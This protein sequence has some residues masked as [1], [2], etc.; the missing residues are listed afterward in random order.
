MSYHFLKVCAATPKIKLGDCKYNTEQIIACMKQSELEGASLTLFPELCITGYTCGDLFFQSTLLTQTQQSIRLLLQESTKHEQLFVIGA[1]IAYEDHLYNTAIVICKGEILGIVPKTYLP[2][3]NEYYEKRWFHSANDRI[4]T[5]ISY[6]DHTV[7][8]SPYLLFQAE[9]IPY[10]TVGIEVCEDLWAVISPSLYHTLAG[11]TVILNPSASNE[12]VGKDSY[13]K[14]LIAQQS[15]RTM[16]SYIYTSSGIGESTTD[17]VFGGH[18]LIYENGHQIAESEL[19]KRDNDLLYG[20]IDLERVFVERMKQNNFKEADK[21]KALNYQTLKFNIK[22]KCFKWDRA[23]DPRPFVPSDENLRKERCKH[24]FNIQ[25]HALAR[26]MEHIQCQKLVLGISGGLDSTLALLVCIKATQILGFSPSHILG[27]TMPG[28]GTS[29]RTYHNAITLMQL[30]GIS[31]KE[32]SIVE[33]VKAHLKD[34]EHDINLHDITYENAQARERTQILMDLSNQFNGIV[35]GTGDL[36]E[37]ALG[38]ATYNGDHMSMYAVNASI[39]KTLVRYL[40]E[41]AAYYESEQSAQAI[42][43]DILDTPVS[44]ELLPLDS[45]GIIAQKTEDIVGPYELHDFYLYYMLRFGFSP[46]KIYF[47]AQKAFQDI[48]DAKTIL[49]WLEIFYKRFFT[50]QFKRSCLPDG[51]K[52]GSICLSPRGDWRMPSDAHNRI[53]LDEIEH[54][55]RN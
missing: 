51:P 1:P 18:K 41:Y 21:I 12:I 43:L 36:S 40:V 28:F 48:Y 50:Q 37:L 5:S 25:A 44:P 29:D 19:F 26:R 22:P 55:K 16:S 13:R 49:K 32:I 52:V 53:W 3:Y 31:V 2:N 4:H 17:V 33:A 47:L 14:G 11:A 35:V 42:L 24:I 38:W 46:S 6:C 8:F 27:V 10:F 39:P 23:I 9:H 34:I 20:T 15:A 45:T 7:P 30:L 54:L